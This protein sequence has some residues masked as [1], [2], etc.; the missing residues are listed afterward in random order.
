MNE[1]I[2]DVVKCWLMFLLAFIFYVEKYSLVGVIFYIFGMNSYI[3]ALEVEMTA[4]IKC[5]LCHN[6][7]VGNFQ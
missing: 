1:W 4:A 7:A 3:C 2:D 5:Q 6:Q